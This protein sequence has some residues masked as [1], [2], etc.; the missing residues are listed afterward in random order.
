MHQRIKFTGQGH[1]VCLTKSGKTP[2]GLVKIS[3]EIEQF[4]KM[5]EE[6]FLSGKRLNIFE[7]PGTH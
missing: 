5:K 7:K 1:K 2:M 3:K 6:L 4:M